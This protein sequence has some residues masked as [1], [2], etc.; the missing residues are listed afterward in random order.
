MTT[1]D[2]ADLGW[3]LLTIIIGLG[4]LIIVGALYERDMEIFVPL[5]FCYVQLASESIAKAHAA[6]KRGIKFRRQL[7]LFL[8]G[9]AIVSVIANVVVVLGL[10]LLAVVWGH[11]KFNSFLI[12]IPGS[13]AVYWTLGRIWNRWASSPAGATKS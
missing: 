8:S 10:S 3:V 1:E 5:A 7:L 9:I 6:A 2:W 12:L 13:L 11:H 4:E